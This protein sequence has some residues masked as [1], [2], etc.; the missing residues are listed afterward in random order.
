M[1]TNQLNRGQNRRLMFIE[2]KSDPDA[3]ARI[4][5]VRFS[6]SGRSIYYCDKTLLKA[7]VPGGN[8]IDLE[9]NDEYWV[10]GVKS[11]GSN[12]HSAEPRQL[13]I[14]EDARLEFALLRAG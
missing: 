10:S 14:D 7:N 12:T 6:R 5:W 4:G 9:S 8:F 3:A 1:R 2:N 11:R 13:E